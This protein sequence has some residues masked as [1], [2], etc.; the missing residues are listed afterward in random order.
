MTEPV[1][2]KKPRGKARV[3]SGKC[4]AC[5]ARCQSVCP[6]DGVE[7]SEQGEPI[8]AAEKCIGCVKCVKACPAGALEMFYTPEELAIIAGFEKHG[9]EEV[10][11][12]ESERRRRISAYKGVWVF[13]EQNDGEAAKV[14]WELTGVGRELADQLGVPLS[15]VVIGSGVEHLADLAFGYGA[16][17][18]FLVND[19]VFRQYRTEPFLEAMC[20]LIETHKPEVVLM[21]ATG[22]GRDLAGAVATR[23]KT[24]LT[25]DCTGLGI[26]AKGNLMQTRPAFGGNIMATIMCDRF[27]PQMATVRPHVMP[28][29][30]QKSGRTG[31]VIHESCPVAES[32]I[33]T[34]VLEVITEKG[35]KDK[36][37]V[38]GAEFIVS[39]GRGLMAKEN[40]ALL[41]ELA[42]EL[43]GVVGGS[44]SAVDAGWLPQDRQV[45]QTGKTVR[46]KIYIACGISGAIQHLVGMQDSDV[47][48]AINRDPEAPIFEVATFGIVGDLFQVVPALTA[49]VREMKQRTA[50]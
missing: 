50:A 49:R 40:F 35:A 4:I 21:G 34:R 17:Q 18:A 36:V 8:I 45:G 48:I 10:D 33:F 43:G 2:L 7:M 44:R 26:D 42:E 31:K 22:M 46:P 39:G 6:V 47:I 12:E 3:I 16:D 20:H 38:A 14:S 15:A 25:A 29:P 28:M 13:I 23:V 30:Q 41:E 9:G 11:E 24:G 32:S 37:D 5:G 19:P 27:R 1:K